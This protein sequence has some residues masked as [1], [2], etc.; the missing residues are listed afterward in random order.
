MR[1]KY[2]GETPFLEL[3][4]GKVHGVISMEKGW[5]C[6]VNDS[7]DYLCLPDEFAVVEDNDGT[8]PVGD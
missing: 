5:C 6:I 1:I 4:R 2:L 7:G 8:A 3:T